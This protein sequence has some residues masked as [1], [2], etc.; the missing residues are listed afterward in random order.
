VALGPV[1]N[2]SNKIEFCETYYNA[3]R[4]VIGDDGTLVVPTYTSQ[5]GREGINFILEETPCMTGIFSEHI[6]KKDTSTRSIHPINSLTSIGPNQSYICENNSTSDFGWDSPFDRLNNLK[7][8][9]ISIGLTAAF[10]L[11]ILH[12]IEALFG[13]PYRYNKILDVDT[14]VNGKKDNRAFFIT[15]RYLNIKLLYNE[16]SWV[17]PLSKSKN[18]AGKEVGNGY[19]F[20]A[21][22]DAAVR[23]ARENLIRNPYFFLETEPHF[24]KGDIPFDGPTIKR[25]NKIK[26]EEKINLTINNIY[27]QKKYFG[28]KIRSIS[29]VETDEFIIKNNSSIKN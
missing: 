9:V 23:I 11:G 24:I 18:I 26:H 4:D 13:L 29:E 27:N 19:I 7:C 16:A 12:Y 1:K 22:F 17:L 5:V 10:S 28:H 8:K 6:R 15:A 20:I 25:D 21:D 14:I 2:V 3:I